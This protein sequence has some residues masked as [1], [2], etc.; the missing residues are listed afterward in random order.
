MKEN[1]L[2]VDVIIGGFMGALAGIILGLILG[3]IIW[4][5]L[6]LSTFIALGHFIDAVPVTP[7]NALGMGCGAVIGGIFGCIVGLKQEK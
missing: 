3:V 5:L 4:I 1:K 2:L 7:I 6:S